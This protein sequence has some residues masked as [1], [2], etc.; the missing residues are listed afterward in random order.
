MRSWVMKL[1]RKCLRRSSTS[2]STA[3][4]FLFCNSILFIS[5]FVDSSVCI[6]IRPFTNALVFAIRFQ[7]LRQL[8]L[9]MDNISSLYCQQPLFAL[10][11]LLKWF[12]KCTEEFS[13][14]II[15]S[16]YIWSWHVMGNWSKHFTFC[17][18]MRFYIFDCGRIWACAMLSQLFRILKR[19]TV[20][21]QQAFFIFLFFLPLFDNKLGN[22]EKDKF[23][24]WFEFNKC[25]HG[26]PCVL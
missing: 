23:Y 22:I 11:S 10:K 26:S 5:Y 6:S 16:A 24:V 2:H 19:S 1:L 9:I 20:H 15:R 21:L 13:V 12:K 3:P 17:Q 14:N 8:K 25:L 18:D 7:G 4:N